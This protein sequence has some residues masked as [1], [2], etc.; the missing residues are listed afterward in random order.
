MILEH[1]HIINYRN[2]PA[3]DFAFSR[4]VNCFVGNN[5]AGKTN[6]LDAIYYLSFCKSNAIASDQANVTHGEDFFLIQGRYEGDLQISAAY[7]TGGRKIIKRDDKAYRR[8][9]EHVGLIPLIMIGPGDMQLVAGGSEDRR[10]FIDVAIA[11]YVPAYLAALIR[12]D[13]T[14]KQRNALLKQEEEPETAML[15][16]LE[17]MMAAETETIYRERASFVEA[18]RGYFQHIYSLLGAGGEQVDIAYRSHA[19]RGPLDALLHDGRPRERAVGH[20]LYGPHRDD[21]ELKLDGYTLKGFGSQGQTKTYFIAMKL[22]QH[23]F[24][25]EKGENN[26]PI[27]LLDDIF[28]KL[29]SSR[30]ERIIDYVAGES[31]GQ[32]FITDTNRSHLD[33]ILRRTRRE[34]KLFTVD[35]GKTTEQ[36]DW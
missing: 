23:A 31:M 27:L 22:A 24:L 32:I 33:H 21:L 2:L 36:S 29:D 5:G 11:Q 6:I 18:F 13:R 19:D 26:T 9:S 17:G 35:N 12:Y 10:R 28:D 1:L 4:N 14:L 8:Y 3:A 25:R 15:D 20:T 30:V 7:R 16:V 34:Y